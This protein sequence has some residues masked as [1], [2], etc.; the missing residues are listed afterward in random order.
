M[1]NIQ[2]SNYMTFARGNQPTPDLS[3][4]LDG[5]AL[6]KVRKA[7]FLG[8]V[9]DES[10]DASLHCEELTKR[11]K[12]STYIVKT[13]CE[14]AGVGIGKLVYEAYIQSHLNYCPGFWSMS[15]KKNLL[16]LHR[17][18]SRAIR[19]IQPDLSKTGKKLLTEMDIL[20]LPLA[21][22]YNLCTFIHQQLTH[23]G[24]QTLEF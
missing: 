21:I 6:A 1:L 10:L 8:C 22:T 2:K 23:R 24:P 4:V 15:T 7:K 17:Q 13:L 12:R 16:R 20:P 9:L 5:A 14:L 3:V 11:L 19:I 18:Q